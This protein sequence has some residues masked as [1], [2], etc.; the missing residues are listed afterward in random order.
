MYS[1]VFEECTVEPD[2]DVQNAGGGVV[3]EPERIEVEDVGGVG[4]DRG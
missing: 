4:E 3:D 2:G 1:L